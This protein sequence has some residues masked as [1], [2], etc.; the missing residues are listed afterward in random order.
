[1][2]GSFSLERLLGHFR[3]RN[4]RHLSGVLK[5]LKDA[6]KHYNSALEHQQLAVEACK[7]WGSELPID[8]AR[9]LI[10]DLSRATEPMWFINP[11]SMAAARTVIDELEVLRQEEDL[12]DKA[13]KELRAAERA[14]YKALYRGVKGPEIERLATNC[15]DCRAKAESG[16]EAYRNSLVVTLK[17]CFDCYFQQRSVSLNT[18]NVCVDG[19][20][21]V[22]RNF[23]AVNHKSEFTDADN[24]A[25]LES[26]VENKP[27]FDRQHIKYQPI[28]D[29]EV[30]SLVDSMERIQLL[31]DDNLK[32]GFHKPQTP[33]CS[34]GCEYEGGP[35]NCVYHQ[36][37][38]EDDNLDDP[39]VF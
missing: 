28:T 35:Y 29:N 23:D 25:Y 20:I 21:D 37:F 11:S 27:V 10:N 34:G 33:L 7:I 16:V 2:T 12:Q 17:H 24:V 32:Y 18:N 9:D 36:T 1:M 19:A 13:V 4:C 31:G 15:E 26:N 8:D 14:Y 39:G 5:T 3:K 38:D 22:L 30:P 6:M